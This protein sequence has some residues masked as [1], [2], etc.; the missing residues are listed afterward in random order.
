MSRALMMMSNKTLRHAH[1]ILNTHSSFL[2]QVMLH[3]DLV[4]SPIENGRDRGSHVNLLPIARAR[5]PDVS[6]NILDYIA[7]K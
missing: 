4:F 5:S 6:H 7:F 3:A 1:E 2:I